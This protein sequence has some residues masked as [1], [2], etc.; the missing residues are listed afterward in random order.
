M[1]SGKDHFLVEDHIRLFQKFKA[2]LWGN[3]GA[4]DWEL[5]VL[6]LIFGSV[7]FKTARIH[8]GWLPKLLLKYTFHH[9]KLFR[10]LRR[11]LLYY[12]CSQRLILLLTKIREANRSL[13]PRLWFTHCLWL[14]S[15]WCGWPRLRESSSASWG[16]KVGAWWPSRLGQ[17]SLCTWKWRFLHALIRLL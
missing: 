16:L 6:R 13:C 10:D 11:L 12:L 17:R 3:R 2:R 15:L 9:F 1:L 14:F 8:A 4:E 7:N 5:D